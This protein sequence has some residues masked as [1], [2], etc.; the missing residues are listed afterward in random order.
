VFRRWLRKCSTKI[1]KALILANEQSRHYPDLLN[2]VRGLV[3]FGVPH[4]GSDV[5]YWGNFAA[6]LLKIT[7]LGFGTNTS[8]VKVLKRNSTAFAEISQQFIGCGA[9][10]PIRTFYETEKFMN[11][12]VCRNWV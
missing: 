5:A 1:I 4:R 9:N 7:Q 10:L 11:Q 12:L 6:N 8:F 3:F 2:S